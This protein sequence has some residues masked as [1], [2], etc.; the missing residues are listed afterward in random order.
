M[1]DMV[2]WTARA[3]VGAVTCTLY[4][5]D[6][7]SLRI[8]KVVGADRTFYL[9]AGGEVV[10][11]FEDAASNTYSPGTT[12]GQMSDT[13]AIFLFH[14]S[15]HLTARVTTDQ[16]GNVSN[17]QGHYPYGEGWY[18]AG[19]A[20]PSVLRKFT[21]YEKDGEVSA[22]QLHAATFRTHGARIGRFLRPDPVHGTST[23]PQRLNRY[24]YVT[25][26]P[27]NKID[28]KGLELESVGL[29]DSYGLD[30]TI[31][32]TI[33][34]LEP[35]RNP[36]AGSAFCP[37]QFSSCEYL[38]FGQSVGFS[39]GGMFATPLSHDPRGTTYGPTNS[40]PGFTSTPPFFPGSG[41]GGGTCGWLGLIGGF[42]GFGCGGGGGP[43]CMGPGEK[44]KPQWVNLC[45]QGEVAVEEWLCPASCKQT[46]SG[47]MSLEADYGVECRARGKRN[48]SLVFNAYCSTAYTMVGVRRYCQCCAKGVK[49]SL[50]LI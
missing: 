13:T 10:N 47:C 34:G 3:R 7:H 49:G 25:G 23:D 24:A 36:R 11:E 17:Q 41:G 2:H 29:V 15:D 31:P 18:A 30:P 26:D 21:S 6:G 8:V 4:R 38:S 9:Y 40:V 46:P 16:A 37:A 32:H 48:K 1:Q 27:V 20:D 42:F 28:P 12:P 19:T 22:G 44:R 14:H 33:G 50:Q 43:E 45:N 5:G 39:G 35:S